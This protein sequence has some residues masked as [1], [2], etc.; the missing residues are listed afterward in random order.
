[1]AQK[2]I[3]KTVK[4]C[5]SQGNL[6]NSAIGWSKNPVH[7][8]NLKGSP[9]R[10]KR[11]NYWAINNSNLSLTIAITT[12]EY[13]SVGFIYLMDYKNNEFYEDKEVIP[14]S[15]NVY[16]PDSLLGTNSFNGK[17]I[18]IEMLHKNKEVIINAS[19]KKFKSEFFIEYPENYESL[20]VVIP[21]NEK[22]FQY[23][24]KQNC[25]PVEGAL[26][27]NN[28]TIIFEKN[29]SLASLDFGR[30]KWPYETFWN[31][32]TFS[33]YISK[34]KIGINFGAK[35]TD[36]TGMNENAIT[37]N[38]KIYKINEDIKFI[39]DKKNLMANWTLKN[40]NESINLK[41][42][43][44]YIRKDRTKALFIKSKFDQ[45]FGY[46]NGYVQIN[47]KKINITKTYGCVEEHKAK[48]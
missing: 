32:A 10:K 43:P 35:W 7:K 24:S 4:L 5:D 45:I 23:T 31:W 8:I 30:G 47:D 1:M 19:S 41:F 33:T 28:Q 36:G 16:L 48:W 21:W 15:M 29:S 27:T 46:F 17:K 3:L 25:L 14:G 20:N 13:A 42:T 38:D 22:R 26:Y 12:F 6:N 40:S 37:Y 2:E 39:Y 44:L 11:W 18:T 34:N 9:F